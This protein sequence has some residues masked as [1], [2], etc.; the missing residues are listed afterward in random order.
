MSW[1]SLPGTTV[2]SSVFCR[3]WSGMQSSHSSQTR[4]TK[5]FAVL[6]IFFFLIAVPVERIAAHETGLVRRC[7]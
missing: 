3:P 6:S 1:P 4:A 5:G 7:P 2:S